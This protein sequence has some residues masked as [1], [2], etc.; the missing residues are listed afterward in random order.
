MSVTGEPS[1]DVGAA[2]DGNPVGALQKVVIGLC[3]CLV[4]LDGF[5]AQA[6]GYVAPAIIRSWHLAPSQMGPVFSA[7][8]IGLMVGALAIAPLADRFGRRPIILAST[9]LFGLFTLVTVAASSIRTLL[10]L[11]FL[12]GLGLG[13]CMPN[14]ISLTS[15]YSPRRHRALLVMLMFTGFTLGSLFAGLVSARLISRYGW[16]AVFA[17]GGCLPLIAVPLVLAILPESIRFLVLR[18]RNWKVIAD[19]VRKIDFSASISDQRSFRIASQDAV[20]LAVGRLFSNGRAWTTCLLWII[21][22]MS[23]LDIYLLVNWLPT[24]ITSGGASM[25]TAIFVGTMLQFGGLIGP[26]PLGWLLD[27]AGPRPPMVLAYLLAA[28]CIA[29]VGIF[30]ST[31][32]PLTMLVVFGAGFGVLGGQTAANAVAAASYPTQIRSTGVG[33]ALGM[34]RV[35]SIIGPALA[36][37]LIARHV[38]LQ[39]IFLLSA[40]PSLLA[41]IAALGLGPHRISFSSDAEEVYNV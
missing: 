28:S 23:L 20:P 17:V 41:A 2:I 18:G 30:A 32:I 31:S 8:L 13:G 19:I 40:I 36:G 26:L 16:Q 27:R 33:W 22:F 6:I 4:L 38:S 7:G 10:I 34:G 25:E 9:L 21:F 11:R 39:N 14:L 15:E 5:D 29:C 35:G 37:V 24:A 1:F 12:T 3:T